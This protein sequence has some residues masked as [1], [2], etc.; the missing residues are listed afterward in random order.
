[1]KVHLC[2]YFCLKALNQNGYKQVEEDVVA[3]GHEGHEVEGSQW[4]GGRHPV[5]EH[6]VPV[7]LGEDLQV[8]GEEDTFGRR[9]NPPALKHKFLA[10]ALHIITTANLISGRKLNSNDA[11]QC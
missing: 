2:P 6:R 4:R 7:L 3:K 11:H 10:A 1:M 9:T 5:V 8:G